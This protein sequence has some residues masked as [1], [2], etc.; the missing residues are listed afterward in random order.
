MTARRDVEADLSRFRTRGW[1]AVLGVLVAFGLVA[2]RAVYLQ[3]VRHEDLKAQAESNRTAVLPIDN[4]SRPQLSNKVL[5][6]CPYL[7]PRYALPLRLCMAGLPEV[8][9]LS[10]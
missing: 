3:V 1:V 4:E 7:F 5:N 10:A 9:L 2:A 6:H 8:L